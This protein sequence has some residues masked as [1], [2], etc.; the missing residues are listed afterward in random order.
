MRAALF[1]CAQFRRRPGSAHT[2]KGPRGPLI[3]LGFQKKVNRH[4]NSREWAGMHFGVF[5]KY[6][7]LGFTR[8]DLRCSEI[9]YA[10]PRFTGSTLVNA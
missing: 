6:D 10:K 1:S 7:F 3:P 8:T 9:E 2:R 4:R 5:T